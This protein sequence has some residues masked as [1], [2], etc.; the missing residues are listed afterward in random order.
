[1]I[2]RLGLSL[3]AIMEVEV[4][5]IDETLSVGDFFFQKKSKKVFSEIMSGSKCEVIVSHDMELISEHCTRTI[6]LN[7]GI[8]EFDGLPKD[9]VKKYTSEEWS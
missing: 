2:S 5:L 7:K 6:V 3:A 4:L 1:M 8:I 9:A